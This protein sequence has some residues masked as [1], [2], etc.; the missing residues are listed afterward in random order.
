M[1]SEEVDEFLDQGFEPGGLPTKE[2]LDA[3]CMTGELIYV[4]NYTRSDGT[5]VSGYYRKC[6]R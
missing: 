4:E 3:R 1:T 2:D 5:K 6:P